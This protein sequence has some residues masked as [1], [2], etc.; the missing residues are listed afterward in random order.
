M[1]VSLSFSEEVGV[2]WRTRREGGSDETEEAK[3][4]ARPGRM[5]D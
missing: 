2:Q 1:S 3:D 4:P 5:G